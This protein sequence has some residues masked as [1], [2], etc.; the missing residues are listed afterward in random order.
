M[1]TARFESVR[2]RSRFPINV[3]SVLI[4]FITRA[5]RSVAP[6]DWSTTWLPMGITAII[7]LSLLVLVSLRPIRAKSYEL[8][9]WLHAAL[10]L[11]VLSRLLFRTSCADHLCLANVYCRILLVGAYYHTRQFK[12]VLLLSD[13]MVDVY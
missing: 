13:S 7:A 5:A 4:C 2:F 9:F 6:E 11:R 10:V 12:F 1:P 3:F 8:F